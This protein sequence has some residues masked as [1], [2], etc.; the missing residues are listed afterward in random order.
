MVAQVLMII[1]ATLFGLLGAAHLIYTFFTNVFDSRDAATT[2]AMKCTSP[3]LSRD[4][5]M[6]SAW[7]GFNASH[8]VGILLFAAVYLL[9]AARHMSLLRQSP[10]LVWL[11][12]LGV[13]SYVVIA[14]RYWFIKP[15]IGA[16]ITT[17]CFLGAALI[18]TLK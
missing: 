5:T 3:V 2:E 7:V 12:V 18:L 17:S 4:M 15:L 6:W 8:S 16:A 11:P 14:L 9:L 1:G 13:G 10:E